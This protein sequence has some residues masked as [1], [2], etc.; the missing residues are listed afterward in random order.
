MSIIRC[1]AIQCNFCLNANMRL[2]HILKLIQLNPP[3][4]QIANLNRSYHPSSSYSLKLNPFEFA[5]FSK[6]HWQRSCN[7]NLKKQFQYFL[8]NLSYPNGHWQTT[9]RRKYLTSKLIVFH[10]N[11]ISFIRKQYRTKWWNDWRIDLVTR[12]KCEFGCM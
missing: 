3:E 4:F 6:L 9:L 12:C 11:T 5:K 2:R 10:F 7:L 8:V 1:D